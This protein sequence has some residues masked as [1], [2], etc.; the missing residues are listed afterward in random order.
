MGNIFNLVLI[1]P[2]TNLLIWFY[3]VI[4]ISDMGLAIVALTILIRLALF[5]SFQ[6]SLR[7]Q[8]QMQELQPKLAELREKH[9]GDKEAETKAIM[10]FYK[11]N[12]INPLASCLPLLVQLPILIALYRVFLTGLNNNFAAMLYPFVNNP[13]SINTHFLGLF[14]LA[15][16]N[17]AFAI[18]AGTAQFIQSKMMSAKNPKAQDQT[19]RM[20]SAQMLYMIPVFTTI[21]SLRLPAGVALYWIVTTL[22]AIL[23]QYYIMRKA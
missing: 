12:K 17:T 22:F 7:S 3:N 16:P 4:P 6:K 9:K 21:I 10:E 23:Q 15:K 5:P 13:G 11:Q 19:S 18:I 1:Q 8:K 14:E 20:M 2:L